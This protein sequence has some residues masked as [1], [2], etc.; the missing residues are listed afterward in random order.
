MIAWVIIMGSA[1]TACARLARTAAA[2]AGRTGPAMADAMAPPPPQD[3]TRIGRIAP[4]GEP[5]PGAG[6]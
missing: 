4:E 6:S 1:A 3:I 2:L 5:A